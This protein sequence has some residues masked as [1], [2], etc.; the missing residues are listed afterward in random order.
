MFDSPWMQGTNTCGKLAN[1]NHSIELCLINSHKLNLLEFVHAPASSSRF[2]LIKPTV[3]WNSLFTPD[4]VGHPNKNHLKSTF[5]GNS[6][7][8]ILRDLFGMVKWP[9]KMVK[10]PPIR[11]WQGRIESPIVLFWFVVYRRVQNLTTCLELIPFNLQGGPLSVINGVI[12]PI[13]RV[14]TPVTH[15]EGHVSGL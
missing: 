8:P 4:F 12:T 7:W 3:V 5:L 1:M 14:I 15:L 10:W 11:G 13:S 6:S 9:L 2:F